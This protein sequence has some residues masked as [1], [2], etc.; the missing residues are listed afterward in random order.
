MP[1]V[2]IEPFEEWNIL[3]TESPM[4]DHEAKNDLIILNINLTLDSNL[5][6]SDMTMTMCAHTLSHGGGPCLSTLLKD[7]VYDG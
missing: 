1:G 5:E 3:V 6:T 2:L 4:R 7:T